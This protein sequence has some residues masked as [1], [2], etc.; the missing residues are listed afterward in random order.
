[1]NRLVIDSEIPEIA[2]NLFVPVFNYA[3]GV[4]D[5]DLKLKSKL[6][7][8][9]FDLAWTDSGMINIELNDE[10]ETYVRVRKFIYD[11]CKQHNLQEAPPDSY[12]LNM[13]KAYFESIKKYAGFIAQYDIIEW[14]PLECTKQ[15]FIQCLRED[16][17]YLLESSLSAFWMYGDQ[18]NSKYAPKTSVRNKFDRDDTLLMYKENGSKGFAVTEK[19]IIGLKN[20]II[21]KLSDIIEIKVYRDVSINISDG[22]NTIIIKGSAFDE[23]YFDWQDEDS[24]IHIAKILRVYCVRYGNNEKLWE[25]NMSSPKPKI[26]N[27]ESDLKQEKQAEN[28]IIQNKDTMFCPYCGKKISRTAKFCN[29]CGAKNTY[30]GEGVKL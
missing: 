28:N 21:I 24:L 7:E 27:K 6:T 14:I 4:E 26:Q 5:A 9:E 2:A 23:D 3:L 8:T 13:L 22:T 30:T 10:P 16:R 17:R 18:W 25:E 20:W 11:F 29:F 1:M 12:Y 19:Y 15:E